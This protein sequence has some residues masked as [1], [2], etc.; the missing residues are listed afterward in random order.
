MNGTVADVVA[1]IPGLAERLLVK[2]VDDGTGHCRACPLG[3]QQGFET[4][5]CPLHSVAAAAL[6]V[7]QGHAPR[8]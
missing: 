7:R 8:A 4:W 6:H 5:P 3:A 2:H 1:A